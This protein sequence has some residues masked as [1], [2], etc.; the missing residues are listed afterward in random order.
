MSSLV[1][2]DEEIDRENLEIQNQNN[3]LFIN[4]QSDNQTENAHKTI[5][6]SAI[7]P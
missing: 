5:I 3:N 2:Q 7:K 1:I 4:K 6:I